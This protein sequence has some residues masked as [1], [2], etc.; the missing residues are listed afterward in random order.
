[1]TAEIDKCVF[2]QTRVDFMGYL[3]S[4]EGVQISKDKVQTI[5]DW[6]DPASVNDVQTFIWFA[7][8]Y[9]RVITEFSKIC[10]SITDTL[11]G[12]KKN[13]S[14]TAI[15]GESFET[16][17]NAFTTRPILRHFDPEKKNIMETDT[18]DFAITGILIQKH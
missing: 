4:P 13:F 2:Y 1:M 12:D 5:T 15:E 18:S 3:L 14:W 7:N 8:F 17:K 6:T 11:N 10:K 16:L 9:H